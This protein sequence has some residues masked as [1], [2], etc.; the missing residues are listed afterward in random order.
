[1]KI[2]KI[3]EKMTGYRTTI[4]SAITWIT[5]LLLSFKVIS[6]ELNATLLENADQ[7]YGAVLV[8][9]GVAFQILRAVTKTPIGESE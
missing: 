7:F 4:L 6:P 3:S 8:A 9:L 1:L 2:G 5:G